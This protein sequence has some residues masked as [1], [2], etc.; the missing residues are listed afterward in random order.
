MIQKTT[1]AALFAALLTVLTPG[2]CIK[3][4]SMRWAICS[5]SAKELPSGSQASSSTSGRLESGK[6]C[7]CTRPIPASPKAKVKSIMPMVI[8]R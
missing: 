4:A 6:N 7:C 1:F 2:S 5:F 8:Q 3:R